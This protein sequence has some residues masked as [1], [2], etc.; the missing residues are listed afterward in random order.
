MARRLDWRLEARTELDEIDWLIAN[1]IAALKLNFKA[2]VETPPGIVVETPPGTVG[3]MR[4][5]LPF[6]ARNKT[7][8]LQRPQPFLFF[9]RTDTL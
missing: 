8:A 1:P 6:P 2:V 9:A 7:V 4:Q 3:S 5:T